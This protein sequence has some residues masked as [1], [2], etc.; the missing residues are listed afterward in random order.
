MLP[1]EMPNSRDA[2]SETLAQMQKTIK[3]LDKRSST[4]FSNTSDVFANV[5]VIG[6]SPNN[7]KKPSDPA[8]WSS[9]GL[10]NSLNQAHDLDTKTHSMANQLPEHDALVELEQDTTDNKGATSHPTGHAPTEN[11]AEAKHLSVADEPPSGRSSERTEKTEPGSQLDI[12]K[13]DDDGVES[14]D[15]PSL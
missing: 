3:R 11:V 12:V 14:V 9:A 13:R 15:G 10:S 2:R 8:P 5:A 7:N 6:L 1:S 4:N